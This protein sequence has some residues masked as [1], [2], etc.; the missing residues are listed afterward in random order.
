MN[1]NGT[2]QNLK[3]QPAKWNGPTVA[4]RI[5]ERFKDEILAMARTLD[6]GEVCTTAPNPLALS[7]EDAVALAQKMIVARKPA[8]NKAMAQLLSAIYGE[9]I[10]L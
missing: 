8:K 4:I 6:N 7:K 5:P 9:E 1:K 10:V 3:P 2:P